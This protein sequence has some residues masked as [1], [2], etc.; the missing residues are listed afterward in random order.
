[1]KLYGVKEIAEALG[2]RADTVSQWI[3]RGKLPEPTERLSAGPVWLASVIEPWIEARQ[4][5]S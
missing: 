3:L 2:V 4:A 1:M 5:S